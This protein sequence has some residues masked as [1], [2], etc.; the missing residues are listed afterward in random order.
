[1]EREV[2]I[3]VG[4]GKRIIPGFRNYDKGDFPHLH[5]KDITK[6]PFNDDTVS[7]IYGSHVLEYF[8]RD[9][10]K[11]VLTEWHRVLKQDGTLRLAV[12]DFAEM[13][14][15]YVKG[16]CTLE[17]ILGPLYGKMKA[18]QETIYHRTVYDFDSLS[19]LLHNVGFSEVKRYNWR[20]TEHRMI[21]DC[22]MAYLPKMDK[23]NGTLISLNIEAKK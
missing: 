22:S 7:L 6:L 16:R 20:D 9:E 21:D 14:Q 3:H 18:G 1:M 8:D 13:S 15:L 10:A 17:Q 11:K 5:G 4:C 2:K 23:E 12:P 19:N